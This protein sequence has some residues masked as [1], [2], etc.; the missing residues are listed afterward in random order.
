MEY[1]PLKLNFFLISANAF[2][3]F[4]A[5]TLHEESFLSHQ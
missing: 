2:Y 1:W 3:E 5:I 4:D